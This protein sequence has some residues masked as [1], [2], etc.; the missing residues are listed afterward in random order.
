[1]RNKFVNLFI[2]ELSLD[3]K[4]GALLLLVIFSLSFQKNIRLKKQEIVQLRQDK[5]TAQSL[6]KQIPELEA[7][8]KALEVERKAVSALKSKANLVLKGIFIK[9]GASAAIINNEIYQK[10]DT[11]SGLLITVITSNTVTFEDPAT[12]EQSKIQLPEQ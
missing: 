10:N 12:G 3:L 7:K 11:V 8:L 2:Q 9:G 6:E 1:M 5:L 4:I